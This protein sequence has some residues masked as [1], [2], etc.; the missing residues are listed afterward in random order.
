[1]TLFPHGGHLSQLTPLF[2]LTFSHFK[3]VDEDFDDFIT[4]SLLFIPPYPFT[5]DLWMDQQG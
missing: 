5:Y 4:S 2:N 3:F 1:M